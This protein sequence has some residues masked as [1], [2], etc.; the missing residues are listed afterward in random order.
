MFRNSGQ[1]FLPEM[2]PKIQDLRRL[3][4]SKGLDP[5]IE[6]DGGQN[7]ESAGLAI[8]AGAD[9]IVAGSAVFGSNDYASAIAQIRSSAPQEMKVAR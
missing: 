9:A 7:G 3:C 1:K 2:V 4:E 5:W 8:A 6:I